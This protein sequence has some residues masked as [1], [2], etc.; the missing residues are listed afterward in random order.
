MVL[1]VAKKICTCVQVQQQEEK[2][3]HNKHDEEYKD[4]SQ[5]HQRLKSNK[6]IPFLRERYGILYNKYRR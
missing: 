6:D 1:S 2:D 4:L 5:K 3:L